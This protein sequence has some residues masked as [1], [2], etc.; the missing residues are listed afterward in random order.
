MNTIA[1]RLAWSLAGLFML[2]VMM[3]GSAFGQGFRGLPELPS[4]ISPERTAPATIERPGLRQI[5]R[6]EIVDLEVGT[7]PEGMWT[8]TATVRNVGTIPLDG[9]ELAVQG[10]S[11]AF[12]PTQNT[13]KPASGSMVS[14]ESLRPGQSA[15]VTAGWTRCCLTH[16][17]KVELRYRPSNQVMDT[18]SV[19]GLIYHTS[20]RRPLNVRVRRIEWDDSAKSWRATLRNHTDFTAKMV[21]QG[22]LW[23][24][25]QNVA[26]PAGGQR[27]TL[28]PGEDGT[29]IPLHAA[30]ASSGDVLKVH[31]WADMNPRACGETWKDC[32]G[33]VSW[34]ITVPHSKTF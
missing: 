22:Y 13:W 23:P 8:W 3:H 10:Y 33:R 15:E 17:L 9:R 34:N 24:E 21:V 1:P 26:V 19:S 29:T 11:I 12:P 32:G 27:L 6:A 5:G 16:E 14:R 4:G 30:N 25:G 18:K 2:F 28:G 31:I 7:N 20:Q